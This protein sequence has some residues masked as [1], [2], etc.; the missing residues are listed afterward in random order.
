MKPKNNQVTEDRLFNVREIAD[1]LGVSRRTIFNM[2]KERMIPYLKIGKTVRF[3]PVKVL[4]ALNKY[5]VPAE[6]A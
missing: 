4:N 6:P 1:H 2:K 5:E 3:D